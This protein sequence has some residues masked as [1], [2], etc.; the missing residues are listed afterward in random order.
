MSGTGIMITSTY[1]SPTSHFLESKIVDGQ[2][3]IDNYPN[4]THHAEPTKN[5]EDD[6]ADIW[7]LFQVSDEEICP[8]QRDYEDG[9]EEHASHLDR[10]A[11]HCE[12]LDQCG[13]GCVHHQKSRCSRYYFWNQA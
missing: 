1:L 9:S 13:K 4:H 8:D 7:F 10:Y 11:V 5:Q 12:L 6:V 2:A 3:Y